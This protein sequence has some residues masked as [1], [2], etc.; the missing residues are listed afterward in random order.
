LINLYEKPLNITFNNVRPG[1][2]LGVHSTSGQY[3]FTVTI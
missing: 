1:N 3:A 2:V